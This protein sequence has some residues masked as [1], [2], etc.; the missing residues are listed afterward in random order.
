MP[1]PMNLSTWPP[2]ERKR[3]GQGL[4]HIV[5]Q[6]DDDRARRGIAG[7]REA[8]DVGVPE[9][10]AQAVDRTALDRA[11]MDAPSGVLA[12]IGRRAGP[13]R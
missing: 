7:R 5:E 10:G 3:G 8:A 2:R 6:I 13:R 4:E 9:H 12:E 1:S 11:G